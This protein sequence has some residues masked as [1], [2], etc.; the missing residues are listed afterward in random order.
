MPEETAETTATEVEKTETTTEKSKAFS[1]EQVNSLLADERRKHD[2]R[3]ADYGDLRKK[4]EAHDK[5]LEAAM[6][7]SEKA[8]AAAR[9]EGEQSARQAVNARLVKSEA[10]ALAAAASFRDAADAVAFLDL[11]SVAVDD[12]GDVDAKAIAAQLKTLSETKPYL[13]AGD[14]KERPK[15]DGAQGGSAGTGTSSVANGR[16]LYETRHKKTS[17]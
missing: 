17:A 3:Y 8:V 5:A 1:Q 15:P 6:S 9:K 2:A 7:E 16:A 14:K 11:S 13:L 4:A 12:E 10:R